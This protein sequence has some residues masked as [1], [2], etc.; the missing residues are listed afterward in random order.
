MYHGKILHSVS[1]NVKAGPLRL[2][3][4]TNAR[5]I[6]ILYQISTCI[7]YLIRHASVILIVGLHLQ[8]RMPT[9][10]QCWKKKKWHTAGSN[11]QSLDYRSNALPTELCRRYEVLDLT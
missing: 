1:P 7:L 6:R 3:Q 2:T 5:K 8:R 11:Q 4:L 10:E 9:S